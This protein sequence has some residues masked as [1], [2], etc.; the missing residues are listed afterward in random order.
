M[1]Q[2]FSKNPKATESDAIKNL[3]NLMKKE[4]IL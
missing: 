1:E 2:W 4:I 3:E